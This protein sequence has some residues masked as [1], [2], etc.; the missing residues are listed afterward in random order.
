M[1]FQLEICCF[2]IASAAIAQEAGAHRIELCAGPEEGGTTASFGTIKTARRHIQLPLFPIIRP[3]GGDFLYSD[4]EFETMLYDLS[5]CKQLSCDGIVTGILCPDGTIDKDRTSRLVELAYP[6]GVTFHRAFDYTR[7]PV[8]ALEDIIQTGCERV[9]TSGQHPLAWDGASL[10][11][12]LILQAN[13]RIVVMPGSGLRAANI[14]QLAEKTKAEEFH[15]SAR[16]DVSGQMQFLN[17][18][19]GEELQ[20]PLADKQEI[21]TMLELL[22]AYFSRIPDTESLQI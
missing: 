7:D 9:L 13:H 17:R 22:S 21:E 20:Y 5:F 18:S 10:V 16:V 4:Q 2:N 12:E 19:M 15:S 6:L 1:S 8:E 3:R 14:I 11:Q